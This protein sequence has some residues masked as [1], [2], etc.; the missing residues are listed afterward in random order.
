MTEPQAPE[1][2]QLALLPELER[3]RSKVAEATARITAKDKKAKVFESAASLP[4]ARVLV[5]V[6]L[7]HLDRPF[8]Y[9]V[10][11]AMD[12]QV[13]PGSRVRVKFA[14]QDVDGF[15][16]ERVEKSDHPGKLAP[17][18]RAVS[19][20]PVLSRAVADLSGSVAARYAGTRSDVLRLAIPP[21]HATTEKAPSP[22]APPAEVDLSAATAAWAGYS[23]AWVTRLAA[24]ES[25]RSV[26]TALPGEDWSA[27]LAHAAAA[28]VASG[29]GV[30]AELIRTSAQAMLRSLYSPCA[31]PEG[32]THKWIIRA[33]A[34]VAIALLALALPAGPTSKGTFG[35]PGSCPR[36]RSRLRCLIPGE[37]PSR[38]NR[39]AS[40]FAGSRSGRAL[41]GW[42]DVP[43]S[44]C[45]G[46]ASG[47]SP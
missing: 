20:E 37:W 5:D 14:G 2:G 1:E 18:R 29:R 16:V 23:E 3:A 11:A 8:D 19:A 36:I 47:V 42:K 38:I 27:L 32:P 4:V 10:P 33:C 9:L 44:S 15:V 34:A 35:S 22:T 26:W 6:P 17:L 24:G 40:R 25:P 31:Y 13:V 12:A 39:S 21:R 43:W 7:A 46:T 28:T 41:P 30:I 45:R